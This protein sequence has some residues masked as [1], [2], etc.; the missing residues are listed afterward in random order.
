MTVAL[1][2]TIT[3]ALIER[4]SGWRE[5]AMLRRGLAFV[6]FAVGVLSGALLVLY[7]A[8]EAALALGLGIMIVTAVA[9]HVLSGTEASWA[10]PRST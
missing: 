2:L 4:G 3:G 7:V 10:A 6:A 8:V 1:S 5:P 9:T